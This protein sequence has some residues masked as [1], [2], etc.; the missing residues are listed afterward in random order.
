MALRRR[1]GD[2][3]EDQERDRLV[4][5]RVE[6][7]RLAH[8]QDR[9]ERVLQSL[10]AAVRDR[11]AVAEA[12]RAEPLAGEQVVGDGRA[13]DRVLVLEQQAG[14]L[15]CALLAGGVDV[16]QHV[17]GGQD[18]GETVHRGETGGA[19]GGALRNDELWSLGRRPAEFQ[20]IRPSGRGA[21]LRAG[22]TARRSGQLS[23]ALIRFDAVWWWSWT[24]SLWRT[25]W[26][27]SL[28]ISWSIAA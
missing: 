14:L 21:V 9:G 8:A 18:G 16:D 27:S 26:R 17:D 24:R 10:D 28:S 3:Q 4:V 20:P 23:V 11:H 13:G 12:G 19:V 5:G 25:T 7:D 22:N 6:G 1:L 2:E 15:E